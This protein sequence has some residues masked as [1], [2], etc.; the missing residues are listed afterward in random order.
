MKHPFQVRRAI[1][2]AL[3]LASVTAV[4]AQSKKSVGP[5]PERYT[6]YQFSYPS[7]YTYMGYFKLGKGGKYEYGRGKEGDARVLGRGRYKTSAKGVTFL[8]GP[9]KGV[10][11]AYELKEDGRHYIELTYNTETPDK[12][13]DIAQF[14]NCDEH[15]KG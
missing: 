11:G 9:L 5:P 4:V 14:C 1:A 15:S 12:K 7:T 10:P 3:L 2:G 8:S 13:D 6:C